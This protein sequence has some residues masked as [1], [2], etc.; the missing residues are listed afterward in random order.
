VTRSD[1]AG[2]QVPRGIEVLV[3]KAAVDPEF[4]ALLL[5]KRAEAANSIGLALEPSEVA[6]LM[7]IQADQLQAM[8][9]KTKVNP[10]HRGTFLGSC[11]GQ[12]LIAV[13]AVVALGVG[14]ALFPATAGISPERMRKIRE[15]RAKQE[16]EAGT[17]GAKA[18]TQD[19]AG[20]ETQKARSDHDAKQ[21]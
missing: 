2:I 15:A 18:S 5:A 1:S 20:K 9:S 6:I 12:M 10:K 4:K 13:G 19:A 16:K 3:K 14:A 11:A 7:S 17:Q 8:I 21:Q